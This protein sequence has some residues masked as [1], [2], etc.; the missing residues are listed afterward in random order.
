MYRCGKIIYSYV[1]IYLKI[2]LIHSGCLTII[3]QISSNKP[4]NE[5]IMDSE[6]NEDVMENDLAL[7]GNDDDDDG[8]NVISLNNI[9]A[10][11]NLEDD[12]K[13]HSDA[14]SEKLPYN[15]KALMPNVKLQSPFQPGSTPSHL[16]SYFMVQYNNVYILCM[17]L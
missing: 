9:K 12:Q 4:E 2:L 10:S 5:A 8:E 11:V 14:S 16:L 3:F 7:L 17:F 15:T 1:Y 6:K 13:S